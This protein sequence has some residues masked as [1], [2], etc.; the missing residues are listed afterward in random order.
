[1]KVILWISNY[2]PFTYPTDVIMGGMEKVELQQIKALLELG[3]DLTLAV[4]EDS[5]VEGLPS[6]T[7][8]VTSSIKGPYRTSKVIDKLEEVI[9]DY[10]FVLTNKNI[11]LNPEAPRVQSMKRWAHKLR[12]INHIDDSFPSTWGGIYNLMLNKELIPHGLRHAHVSPHGKTTWEG[13]AEKVLNGTAFAKQE[14]FSAYLKANPGPSCTDHYEVMVADDSLMPLDKIRD[15]EIFVHAGRPCPTKGGVTACKA[16]KELDLL[17]QTEVYTAN[18]A[19]PKERAN[20]DKMLQV[21]PRVKIGLPHS[22]LMEAFCRAKAYVMPTGMET[23]GGIVAFEAAAHG[24]PVVTS[25]IWS[26]RYLEPYGLLYKIDHRTVKST[27]EAI[28]RVSAGPAQVARN[29]AEL[30]SKVREDYSWDA[31]KS[32]LAEFLS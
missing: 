14:A 31:Y 9:D 22:D 4:S 1:M 13:I 2:K 12:T 10:D 24:V 11:S 15:G 23:A 7:L 32:Q 3:I 17:E 29:R 6:I 21:E 18:A 26:D 30:A 5:T 27:R 19:N 8:P 28:L 25:S 16:L 20:L